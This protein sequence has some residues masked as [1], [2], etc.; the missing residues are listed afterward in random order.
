MPQF[1]MPGVAKWAL[2]SAADPLH[3]TRGRAITLAVATHR[4]EG[5]RGEGEG[6]EQSLLASAPLEALA[7]RFGTPLYVYDLDA[8]EREARELDAAFAGEPHLVA[9][10]IKAN[11][12]GP[13]VRR[14]AAAGCGADVVSG[15]E[16]EV[17]LASGILPERILYNGVAKLDDEL[18]RAITVSEQGIGSI[19]MESVEEIDRVA[20]IARSLGRKARVGLRINPEIDDLGTHDAIATGHDEAKFGVALADVGLALDRIRK[21]PSLDLGGLTV[22]VGSQFTSTDDYRRGAAKLFAIAREVP[23]R[24]SFRFLDTGGGFGID[25]G[26]GCDARPKDF[27]R[28][29]QE[30]QRAA[31]LAGI[32]LVVEPGRRLVASYGVLVARVVQRKKAT[33]LPW[34]FVDAGMNDLLRPALYQAR[35]R[36]VALGASSRPKSAVRVAGPVCESSDDFGAFELP[37]DATLV[38]FLDAGAYGFT[39][40]SQY[41]GRA[42]PAEVFLSRAAEPL[43]HGRAEVA[44]WVRGRV[45]EAAP[46]NGA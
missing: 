30:E 18:R 34:V 20:A 6:T 19:L 16:L 9:Y 26:E 40:A 23:E 12:A 46:K 11:S 15:G 7:A 24:S 21:E 2:V 10:A 33:P 25:Y 1:T 44:A 32:R 22:H 29:A 42:L 41:N 27:V 3:V 37:D 31:G 14:L 45:G 5:G 13:V 4:N 28:A 8:I 17:A 39:M 43:V 36:V 38:A 35:H